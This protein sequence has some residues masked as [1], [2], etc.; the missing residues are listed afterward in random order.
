MQGNEPAADDASF[1]ESAARIATGHG[2]APLLPVAAAQRAPP[3][4]QR[5]IEKARRFVL[6]RNIL[7]L[8]AA[9]Q[10]QRELAGAQV[11]A[12]LIK[13]AALLQEEIYAPGERAM[14]DVDVLVR[15][16]DLARACDILRQAGWQPGDFSGRGPGLHARQGAGHHHLSWIKSGGGGL[17]LDLH[18]TPSSGERRL[19]PWKALVV[20]GENGSSAPVRLR[21]E[22]QLWF[23]ATNAAFHGF[24]ARLLLLYD[25]SRYLKAHAAELDWA[26]LAGL[27]ESTATRRA[28]KLSLALSR[29]AF[30]EPSAVP[31]DWM[32]TPRESKVARALFPVPAR[33]GRWRGRLL[34]VWA[35]DHWGERVRMIFAGLARIWRSRRARGAYRFFS[36]NS[37]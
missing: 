2:L 19:P 12:A 27:A 22:G 9:S 34:R 20:E 35:A 21:P 37:Q 13:G 7:Q 26:H 23:L 32:P 3:D 17:A 30:G 33:Q 16:E 31:T 24:T 6:A 28:V 4:F 5:E 25:L 36:I 15:K 14:S 29:L 18:F 8:E 1:W 11:P 10:I